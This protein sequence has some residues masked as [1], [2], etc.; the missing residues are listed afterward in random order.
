MYTISVFYACT[1][2]LVHNYK[3]EVAKSRG[4]TIN[5]IQNLN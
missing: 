1:I 2:E 5:L 3:T 4:D